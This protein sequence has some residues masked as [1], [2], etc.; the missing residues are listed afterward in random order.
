MTRISLALCSLIAGEVSQHKHLLARCMENIRSNKEKLS[1]L[2]A[3]RDG[4]ATQLSD[5]DK[6]MQQL[7]VREIYLHF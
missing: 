4:L 5:R 2:T 1:Q 3:D 6:E 7:Q